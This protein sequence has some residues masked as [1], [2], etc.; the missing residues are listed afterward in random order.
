M[1]IPRPAVE[2]AHDT[3]NSHRGSQELLENVLESYTEALLPFI[4][5]K[6]QACLNKAI[7]AGAISQTD[8]EK[9]LDDFA[10]KVRN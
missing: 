1:K 6:V 7:A 3:F 8:A 10:L 4:E 2:A 5:L 9:V